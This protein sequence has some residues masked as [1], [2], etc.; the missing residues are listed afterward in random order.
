MFRLCLGYSGHINLGHSGHYLFWKKG[1]T[2]VPPNQ[3]R[4]LNELFCF[5]YIK[6]MVR[7]R[8]RKTNIGLTSPEAMMSAVRAVLNGGW[9]VK[10]AAEEFHI[11][12]TTLTRYVEKCRDQEIDWD[13]VLI[14]EL[15]RMEPKYNARQ[16]FST[17]EESL[18]AEYL[19]ACAKLHHGLPPFIARQLAYEYAKANAKIMPDSWSRDLAAGKDWF[20][21]FIKRNA[22][23]SLRTPEATSLARAMG[24]N[25]QSV[26][27]FYENLEATLAKYNLGPH[28]IYNVDETGLTTVQNTSKVIAPKG[29]KQLGQITSA[30]RGELVTACCAIN[31]CGNSVPPL[32]IFP[33]VNF[34][35]HMIHGAPAGTIGCASPSGWITNDLFLQWLKHFIRHSSPSNEK[36]VLLIMDNLEAH[37]TY[38][39]VSLAK[40][41]G[42]ILLTLPPH[43]S[44][45]LQPLDKTVYGPLK[46]YYNDA[47]RAWLL[48]NPGRRITIY[49]ISQIFGNA[50]P[51]AFSAKNILSGFSATG[52]FP[53]NRNIFQ[54]SDFS[55][56]EV[57][58]IPQVLDGSAKDQDIQKENTESRLVQNSS[59]VPGCSGTS[60]L[61]TIEHKTPEKAITTIVSPYNIK[62]LPKSTGNITKGTKRK[63]KTSSILT[64][65]P[66][67]KELEEKSVRILNNAPAVQKVKRNLGLKRPKQNKQEEYEE[68]DNESNDEINFAESEDDNDEDWY[69]EPEHDINLNISRVKEG[70]FVLVK[71]AKKKLIKCFVGQVEHVQGTK[72]SINFMRRK[73][74]GDTFI[75]PEKVDKDLC[76]KSDLIAHLPDPKKTGTTARAQGLHIFGVNFFSYNVE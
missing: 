47:C 62:P 45:R 23:L 75:F 61:I 41:S 35:T 44:H 58:D 55:A 34:K 25:R 43:T 73:G 8:K 49:E 76:E 60:N 33:R 4:F 28:Q 6:K 11:A 71:Y 10:R 18:L 24:F 12:R 56:A 69:E 31:A 1:V 17:E 59:P 2:T 70:S 7:N 15:P 32:M 67:I 42:V 72:Y 53:F 5:R 50:Y 19:K 26:N 65:T 30:E 52:I 21:A 14:P 40:E 37:I 16:V 68:T 29:I 13:A 64:T 22:D 51:Q 20:T 48:S 57:T 27:L 63:K 54:D 36:P 74:T 46:K 38:A 3:K 9:S 66:N 39:S